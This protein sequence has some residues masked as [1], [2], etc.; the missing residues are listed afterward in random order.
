MVSPRRTAALLCLAAAAALAPI[1]ARVG[2][3]KAEVALPLDRAAVPKQAY[4]CPAFE[5]KENPM[6]L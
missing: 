5:N 2:P 6:L 4:K 3:T 1:A